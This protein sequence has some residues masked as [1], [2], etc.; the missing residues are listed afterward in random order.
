MLGISGAHIEYTTIIFWFVCLSCVTGLIVLATRTRIARRGW[1]L[2]Y[3]GILGTAC[4]GWFTDTAPLIYAAAV[5]WGGLILLPAILSQVYQQRVLQQRYSSARSLAHLISFLHPGDGWREQPEIL[6]ALELAQRGDLETARA[7]L[8]KYRES[9][10]P[11]ALSAIVNFYR[12]TSQWEDLLAWFDQHPTDRDEPQILPI[13]LRTYGETGKLDAL[14]DLYRRQQSEITKLVPATSRDLCRLM[15]FA[16]T[17]QK[18]ATERLLAGS[19]A[20]LPASVRQFWLATAV[21][22]SGE[23]EPA[24]VQFEELLPAADPAMRLA[25]ERRLKQ[26]PAP[27]GTISLDSAAET[28]IADAA[29]EHHHEESFG[30]GRSLFTRFARAT[31]IIILLNVIMFVLEMLSGGSTNGE[32]LYRLGALF[33]PAVREGEWWRLGASIFLHFGPLHLAMNMLGLWLLAPFVEHAL[34]SLRFLLLYLTAGIG[35]MAI[36]LVLS[37]G[38]AGAHLTVGASGSVLGLVGATGA[39]MLQ[40]WFRERALTAKRRFTT[41][42]LIVTI[43]TIFDSVVP[44]VSMTAHL[45]GALIGFLLALL[46]RHRLTSQPPAI[47]TSK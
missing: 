24:R 37:S 4:L 41:M 35:S 18:Q 25:I 44:Q 10:S 43:Q 34:G 29:L 19:L 22:S 31:Q 45:S 5:L 28:L 32:T 2:L 12:M 30:T 16:F 33:P 46:L 39:I 17:G 47:G 40:A 6:G 36:V 23:I 38:P 13:L 21:Q 11:A 14:I 27:A 15:L 26:Q 1:V 9:N 3:C 7:R 42:L 8:A 20:V